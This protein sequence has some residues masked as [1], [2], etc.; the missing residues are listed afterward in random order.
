MSFLRLL[1]SCLRPDQVQTDSGTDRKW[2]DMGLTSQKTYWHLLTFTSGVPR[3][4]RKALLGGLQQERWRLPITFLFPCC[5][6]C[7]LPVF[8]VVFFFLIRHKFK[9]AHQHFS[10][11]GILT[12]YIFLP[13]TTLFWEVSTKNCLSPLAYG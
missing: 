4:F 11:T 7:I 9:I 12:E 1:C 10:H 8:G 5:T 13:H 2:A 6:D 3:R